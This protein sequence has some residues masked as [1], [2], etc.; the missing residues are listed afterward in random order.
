MFINSVSNRSSTTTEALS[1]YN[2]RLFFGCNFNPWSMA[3]ITHLIYHNSWHNYRWNLKL[4]LAVYFVQLGTELSPRQIYQEDNNPNF[5]FASTTGGSLGRELKTSSVASILYEVTP[6]IHLRAD[7]CRYAF[8]LSIGCVC[9]YV[10][11]SWVSNRSSFSLEHHLSCVQHDLIGAFVAVVI[12]N[13]LNIVAVTFHIR[14]IQAFLELFFGIVVFF[15]GR[16]A[17]LGEQMLEPCCYLG[18]ATSRLP[19]S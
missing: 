1:F 19:L 16:A 8:G 15:F 2:F 4:F 14:F 12:E 13:D 6:V 17:P 3:G 5:F 18:V 11:H 7:K 9:A 10:V